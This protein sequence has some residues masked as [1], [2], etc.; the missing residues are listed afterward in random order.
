MPLSDRA[1]LATWTL[2]SKEGG[3]TLCVFTQMNDAHI[4]ACASLQTR[5]SEV[6]EVGYYTWHGVRVGLSHVV[7]IRL[8]PG[9]S[10]V[11][12]PTLVS[13]RPEHA[14]TIKHRKIS[15]LGKLLEGL[16]FLFCFVLFLKPHHHEGTDPRRT[17]ATGPQFSSASTLSKEYSMRNELISRQ[18]Q[19][20]SR[21]LIDLELCYEKMLSYLRQKSHL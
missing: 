17:H 11:F 7:T 6:W 13:T 2:C 12:S 18:L 5:A 1:G 19:F 4:Q 20:P 9:L 16:I 14:F 15:S 10:P 3:R 21:T 8:S